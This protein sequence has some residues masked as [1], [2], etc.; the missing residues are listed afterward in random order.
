MKPSPFLTIAIILLALNSH[1][2]ITP[3]PSTSQTIVQGFGLGTITLTYSRPNMK[4]RKIFGNVEPYDKVWRTGANA[5]TVI[6]FSD[7][8]MLE[9]HAV[10]AGEYGLFSLPGEKQWTIILSKKPAQ[11]GAY[12]Y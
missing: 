7:D 2:Q 9:G 6:K 11:W 1:G 12:T 10:A 3:Q 8:V 5:A 4:G